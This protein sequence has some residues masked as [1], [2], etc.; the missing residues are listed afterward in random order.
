VQQRLNQYGFKLTADGFFGAKTEKAVKEY[1]E[2][3]NDHDPSILVDGNLS[4]LKLGRLWILCKMATSPSTAPCEQ[5][6]PSR[7]E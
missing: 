7:T 1:Q 2:R 3:G 6:F 5:Y 4:A